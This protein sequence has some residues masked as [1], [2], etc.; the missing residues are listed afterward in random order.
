M[1]SYHSSTTS[2]RFWDANAETGGSAKKEAL[3]TDYQ[4]FLTLC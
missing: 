1:A 3:L 2:I 4:E